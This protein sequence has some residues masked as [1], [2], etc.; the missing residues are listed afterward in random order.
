MTGEAIEENKP[1]EG[2]G[3]FEILLIWSETTLSVGAQQTALAALVEAG[4]SVEPGCLTGGC[5]MCVTEYVEGDVIHKDSCLS[6]QEQE[7]YF[8][9]CVSRARTRIVIAI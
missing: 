6:A 9:P 8:C 3:A 4:V 1:R 2:G 5:G 7:H